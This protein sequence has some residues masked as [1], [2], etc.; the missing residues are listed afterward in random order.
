MDRRGRTEIAIALA[1]LLSGGCLCQE[2]TEYHFTRVP[3]SGPDRVRIIRRHIESDASIEAERRADLETLID[4]LS[5]DDVLLDALDE[6]LYVKDR[7]LAVERGQLVAIETAIT[8]DLHDVDVE[9]NDRLLNFVSGDTLALHVPAASLVSTNGRRIADRDSVW[10]VWP[11]DARQ[12]DL[13]VRDADFA[14]HP[15]SALAKLYLTRPRKR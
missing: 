10:I 6:G 8:R 15:K 1:G 3:P 2:F 11:R 12:L 9:W 14:P 7:R 4:L 5:S 13:V